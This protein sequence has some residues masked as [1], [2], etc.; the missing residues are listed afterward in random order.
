MH[1]GQ[2]CRHHLG[3]SLVVKWPIL[4]STRAWNKSTGDCEEDGILLIDMSD[5]VPFICRCFSPFSSV[6]FQI[7]ASISRVGCNFCFSRICTIMERFRRPR[8]WSGLCPGNNEVPL[9]PQTPDCGGPQAIHETGS[10]LW[11]AH[12]CLC[13]HGDD[14]T[15]FPNTVCVQP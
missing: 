7:R 5:T 4:L 14:W 6:I 9:V 12:E 10:P 2:R 15:L 11:I 3:K 1:F 13:W 8:K